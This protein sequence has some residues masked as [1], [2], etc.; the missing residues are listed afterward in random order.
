[1]MHSNEIIAQGASPN[2]DIDVLIVR[3]CLKGIGYH[4]SEKRP[5]WWQLQLLWLHWL[6]D[7]DKG[8]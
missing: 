3:I 6:G 1:M 4:D 7:L 8:Q 2:S 5:H